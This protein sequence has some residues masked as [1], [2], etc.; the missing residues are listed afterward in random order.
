MA[1]FSLDAVILEQFDHGVVILNESREVCYWNNKMNS[2]LSTPANEA[3]GKPLNQVITVIDNSILCEKI[4][5]CFSDGM[6]QILSSKLHPELA[7]I[8]PFYKSEK[9][10]FAMKVV[11]SPITSGGVKYCMLQFVDQSPLLAH[12][13]YVR[14]QAET[15]TE[16]ERRHEEDLKLANIGQMAATVVHEINNPLSVITADAETLQLKKR[17]SEPEYIIKKSERML[18]MVERISQIIKGLKVIAHQG[19]WDISETHSLTAVLRESFELSAEKLSKNK[20]LFMHNLKDVEDIEIVCNHVQISQIVVNLISNACDAILKLDNK[21]IRVELSKTETTA[22]IRV[23]DCG[24]GLPPEVKEKI[25]DPFFT[26]KPV[27]KGTGLGLSVS[28]SI[29]EA[30]QGKL[31]VDDNHKNTCFCL[32]LP[33]VR[34]EEDKEE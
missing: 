21:W 11:L 16:Q 6:A 28:Q 33:L 3:V 30:H 15:I 10:Y 31:W 27:G 4:S 23:I 7:D 1:A 8:F 17:I 25:F 14:I 13:E 22:D 9:K 24:S 26:S 20:V 29:A 19:D 18:R 2:F 12:E 5:L 34:K 32:S